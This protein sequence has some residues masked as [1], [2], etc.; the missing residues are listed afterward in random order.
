[1][2]L[3]IG[4]MQQRAS[5]NMKRA[6]DQTEPD[7]RIN[8]IRV[9]HE[10]GGL[11]SK[12][13]GASASRLNEW[14]EE[15]GEELAFLTKS[16]GTI[17]TRELVQEEMVDEWKEIV[18]GGKRLLQEQ[19]SEKLAALLGKMQVDLHTFE[20]H[21]RGLHVA[22]VGSLA[23]RRQR[24][25][26]HHYLALAGGILAWLLTTVLLLSMVSDIVC[27]ALEHID[28]DEELARVARAP[29]FMARIN[30]L[31]PGRPPARQDAQWKLSTV[32]LV[33]ERRT[34]ISFEAVA[35]CGE[36]EILLWG[37]RYKW[38]GYLKSFQRIFFPAFD[39]ATW[40]A[41]RVQ[42]ANGLPAPVPVVHLGLRKKRFTIGSIILT[43]YMTDIQPFKTF[44]NGPFCLMTPDAQQELLKRFIGFFRELH[45]AGL[46]SVMLRYVHAKNLGDANGRA[47]FY[48]FD[49]DKTIV[50]DSC[51]RRI[52]SILRWRDHWRL[53]QDLKDYLSR[54]VLAELR[55]QVLGPRQSEDEHAKA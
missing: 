51:P 45:S 12:S 54:P 8:L 11:I 14:I 37:K 26:L 43:E 18:E 39:N 33:S 29:Q 20:Q 13:P 48:L 17:L 25:R 16:L 23:E 31:R 3:L 24:A 6:L 36:D 52:A 9:Q 22:A 46:Y 49:L 41:L 27:E 2:S 55:E 40:Q 30:L 53:F 4:L 1:M 10:V 38:A 42:Q 21:S 34:H 5:D 15:C 47:E 35:R 19:E 50:W 7:I 44:L 28:L 32:R